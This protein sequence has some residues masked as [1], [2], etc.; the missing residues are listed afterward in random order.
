MPA[1]RDREEKKKKLYEGGNR[2]GK[3]GEPVAR[4]VKKKKGGGGFRGL[5][6]SS[7]EKKPKKKKKTPPKKKKGPRSAALGSGVLTKG[8]E[9]SPLDFVARGKKEKVAES[10][11]PG[12]RQQGRL[13][14]REASLGP[15]EGKEEGGGKNGRSVS[16][17]L[18]SLGARDLK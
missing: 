6:R 13:Q 9:E 8:V 18:P 10:Y 15:L 4:R 2:R 16:A 12:T 5:V 11:L 3:R 7:Q 17:A 1:P 14:K